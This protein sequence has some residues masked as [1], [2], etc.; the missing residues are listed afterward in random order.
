MRTDRD[1]GEARF[2][3][4]WGRPMIAFG[5]FLALLR[6]LGITSSRRADFE[7]RLSLD[8]FT[9][10]I[11]RAVELGKRLEQRSIPHV[12]RAGQT[13]GILLV[14]IA[15]A[16][17]GWKR[18]K[19]LKPAL[20]LVALALAAYAQSLLLQGKTPPGVRLFI[21]A[22]LLAAVAQILPKRLGSFASDETDTALAKSA[23]APFPVLEIVAL[24]FVTTAA[25]V[26]RFYALNQIPNDFDGEAAYFM[27]CATSFRGIA[28][29]NAGIANGPSSSFGSLYYI[30]A[31]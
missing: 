1:E 14:L 4:R 27:A 25:L 8:A 22:L 13:I 29:V 10:L 6:A 11:Q 21:A 18:A 31:H 9:P 28:L 5:A 24:A 19:G 16:G 3:N 2:A 26:Y 12:T 15:V 23:S 7:H 30:T 20:L 17:L